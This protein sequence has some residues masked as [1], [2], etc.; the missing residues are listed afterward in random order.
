[1]TG[2]PS[3]SIRQKTKERETRSLR[4]NIKEIWEMKKILSLILAL[5]VVLCALPFG[6]VTVNAEISGDYIYSVSNGKATITG[7]KISIG[8]SITIP[9]TLGGYPVTSIGS[10]AFYNCSLASVTIPNSVT[11]IGSS[12]FCDCC[13]LTSVTIPNSVTSIGSSA[14]GGCRSLTYV[15]IGY[16]VTSIGS[17][18]FNNCSSLTYITVDSYNNVYSSLNGVLFNKN[19]TTLICY[20]AGITAASYTIPDSVTSIGDSAFSSCG[21]LNSV[22]IPDS[23]TS[24]GGTVFSN[25]SSLNKVNITDLAAWCNIDFGSS[26]SNPL[27]YAKNLYINGILATNITIP[28]SI[29]KIKDFVFSGCSSL[30]YIT[31]PDNVIS[32]GVYAFNNCSSLTSVTIPDS[33]I[34]IEYGAFQYCGALTTITIP[35]N[36]ISIGVSAFENC[37]SLTSI[38]IPNSVTIID[39]ATFYNCTL[40]TSVKIPNSVESINNYSFYDCNSLNSV[41][42]P[43]SVTSIGD[44]AFYECNNIEDVY[45]EG[46]AEDWEKITI[47]Y[48]NDPLLNATIHFNSSGITPNIES[49]AITSFP[50]KTTY[51]ENEEDLDLSGGILTVY[52]EG[53]TTQDIDLS[54]LDV[55]GFDNSVLGEQTLTVKY[56]DF[57]AQFKVNVVMKPVAF[58]AISKTP[59]KVEYKIGDSLDLK[60]AK[61]ALVY[62]EGG[63]KEFDITADMV[64]GFD[65]SKAGVQFITVNYRGFE[66]FFRITVFDC[67]FNDDGIV[68]AQDLAQLKTVLLQNSDD[69]NFD[70]NNDG[71]INILDLIRIKKLIAND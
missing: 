55:T 42:I 7:Y 71:K 17:S 13:S 57:S 30:T 14:F 56:D 65:A 50:T 37:S 68:N 59:D 36:V 46:N 15:K 54:T 64:S 43:K 62:P 24:I 5:T 67:D 41:T 40:L 19:K 29:T 52:Y 21:K 60:G 35:N 12:A 9:S 48:G 53:G 63:F 11:S 70:L 8:R 26:D 28:D 44:S 34:S 69:N 10:S 1:M 49:V 31:I 58:V 66:A 16:S 25:C 18:V 22:T 3:R 61:L 4:K 39:V 27:Y 47:A 20:P 33:V 6:T 51:I 32:I 23:V 2:F 45:Y 38:T